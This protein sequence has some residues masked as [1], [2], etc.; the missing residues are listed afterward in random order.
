MGFGKQGSDTE[1]GTAKVPQGQMA[2]DPEWN[3]LK[4][5]MGIVSEKIKYLMCL[6]ILRE[7]FHW[8]TIWAWKYDKHTEN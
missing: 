3:S 2:T 7:N 1:T 5:S 8:G 4:G 6:H